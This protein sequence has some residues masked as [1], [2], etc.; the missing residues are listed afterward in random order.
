MVG[1]FC[2][3]SCWI[4][5]VRDGVGSSGRGVFGGIRSS[6][7]AGLRATDLSGRRLHLDAGILGM[8]RRRSGL[9]LGAGD[10]GASP[11]SWISVDSGILGLGRR[12][13]CFP[14]GLLGTGGGIL[15][16]Y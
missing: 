4:G 15:R 11:A 3:A 13:V 5:A 10:L 9:L 12:G 7:V 1:D 2:P 6:G 16:R 8:G 14:C